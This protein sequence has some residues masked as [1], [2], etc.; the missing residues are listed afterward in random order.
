M[1]VFLVLILLTILYSS[2]AENP[3][4]V[5]VVEK[6]VIE[7]ARDEYFVDF[8]TMFG[9]QNIPDM[10]SGDIKTNSGV[11]KLTN[12]SPNNL[13]VTFKKDTNSV[14]VQITNTE[15]NAHVNYKYKKSVISVSGDATVKGKIS[16]INMNIALDKVAEDDHFLPHVTASDFQFSLSGTSFHL[17]CKHCPGEV[18][19]L[20]SKWMKGDLIKEI[21]K[22]V[23]SQV[24][25]QINS[26]G[27]EIIAKELPRTLTLL[28]NIDISTVL[29][30]T[31]NIEDDHVE[32]PLDGTLFL[33]DKGYKRPSHTQDMPH[34]NPDDEGEMQLFLNPYLL[35]TFD[36]VINAQ[37]HSFESKL[38][39]L[40][41]IVT[42]D[43][44]V[45]KTTLSFIDGDL[46]ID[47]TPKVFFTG[48]KS[49]IQFESQI[50]MDPDFLKGDSK[51]MMSVKL[52]IDQIS[53]KSLTLTL[54]GKDFNLNPETKFLNTI[55]KYVLNWGIIPKIKIPKTKLLSL[56]VTNSEIDFHEDYSELGI[57]FEF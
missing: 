31:I 3:A 42:I 41:Y 5:A 26:Q 57:S 17:N 12:N 32:V 47:A 44:E 27:N 53:L 18:E 10:K 48:L 36:D 20:I 15:M 46:F 30:D 21:E 16:D 50:K 38:L 49:G 24:P 11:V 29:T 37:M 4:I 6:P 23:R 33:H 1:K 56:K 13:Q 28:G 19:K 2:L 7:K 55:L 14:G 51:N 52:G 22:S 54:F 9:T 8:F 39:G 34:F 43:P 45:G 25:G 35:Q 40:K